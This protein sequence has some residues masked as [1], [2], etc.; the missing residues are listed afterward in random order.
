METG[1]GILD[2]INRIRVEKSKELLREDGMTQE[3]IAE[4]TGFS[5]IRTCLLY[6]SRCV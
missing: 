3:Q 2:F 6:T 4:R 1:G 5:N